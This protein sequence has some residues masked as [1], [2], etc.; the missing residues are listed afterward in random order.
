[1]SKENENSNEAE[2]SALN[3][4]D[5]SG[6]DYCFDPI[7]HGFE[8]IVN[9]AELGFNYPMIE[10]YFVKVVCYDNFGDLIYWYKVISTLI[11]FDDDDRIVHHSIMNILEPIFVS[12][13]TA[14][15]YSCIKSR[16]VHKASYNL[17]RVFKD[18]EGTKY[19]LKLDIKKF[20]PSVDNKILKGLLR[21]K[22]KDKVLLNML[23]EIID[24]AKGLPIGNYLSQYL[25]NFYLTYF[26]HYLKE[27]L[28]VK[29]YFRYCDDIVLLSDNKEQLHSWFKGIETY[30]IKKLNLEINKNYQIFPVEDRGIDWCGYKHYH[31]HTLIRKSIKKKY[32]KSKNKMNH[33]GWLIHCNSINLR[34]KYE[35][36]N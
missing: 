15:T 28:K 26:D 1:M 16:G 2:N 13:F 3:I 22:F 7:K 30:L 21:R 36:N 8:P 19:C 29:Y 4:A 31:S 6:S 27:T 23:D 25:G 20:Y 17:R 24:S 11:G 5:V 18:K 34:R 33:N 35:N 12:V 9:Y 32:I 10:G 14:D